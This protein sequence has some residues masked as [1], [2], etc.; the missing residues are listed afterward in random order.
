L[1]GAM[2]ALFGVY[3]LVKVSYTFYMHGWAGACHV[4]A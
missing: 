4:A 3:G 2:I 1:V